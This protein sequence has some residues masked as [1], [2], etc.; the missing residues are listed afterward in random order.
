M[1]IDSAVDI[2]QNLPYTKANTVLTN[3]G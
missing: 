2:L 3:S 1:I